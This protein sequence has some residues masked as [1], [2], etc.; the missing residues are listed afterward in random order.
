MNLSGMLGLVDLCDGRLLVRQGRTAQARECLD[1]IRHRLRKAGIEH[2]L[3][4]V[5]A[6]AA[7]IEQRA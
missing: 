7:E 4:P 6:L 3:G 5:T 2:L 1:R